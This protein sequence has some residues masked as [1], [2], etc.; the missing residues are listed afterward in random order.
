MKNPAKKVRKRKRRRIKSRIKKVV[1]KKVL[2]KKK[3]QKKSRQNLMQNLK[4][5]QKPL[6]LPQ[7]PTPRV[8]PKSLKNPKKRRKRKM[9]KKMVTK[10]TVTKKIR[11]RK[12][13]KNHQVVKEQPVNLRSKPKIKSKE[14]LKQSP[15]ASSNST[16]A[17]SNS[18]TGKC[19]LC[20]TLSSHSF[21]TAIDTHSTIPKLITVITIRLR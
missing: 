3:N 6:K 20:Y 8:N 1:I 14:P 16:P 11:K 21:T 17:L 7:I 2:L 10:K 13:R 18:S 4:P 9:T 19:L 12:V 15:T 5:K